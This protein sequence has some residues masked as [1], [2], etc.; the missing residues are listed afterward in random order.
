MVSAAVAALADMVS[1][2]IIRAAVDN[3]L[4]GKE[5]KL[6]FFL[7]APIKWAG[8]TAYLA[9]HI[10]IMAVAI[11]IVAAVKVIAQY[12]FRVY[13]TKGAETLTKTMRDRLFGHIERLPYAWHAK[14]RTG[15]IIQRCTSDI[16]TM[17]RFVSEQM[18]SIFRI[19]V[20]L[21]L[22]LGFM[23]SMN[24]KLTLVAM[25]PVPYIILR[26][27]QFH[28]KIGAAKQDV[29][30][31]REATV[32]ERRFW[33]AYIAGT[34][35]EMAILVPY[36]SAVDRGDLFVIAGDQYEVVQKDRKDTKPVSWLL[37][38]KKAVVRYAGNHS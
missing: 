24:W 23:L 34:E 19:L 14:H 37:S 6:P 4:G 30:H 26:S 18:T 33:D 35:L 22:S 27:F 32:G 29:I 31:F 17:K 10:W 2:Q 13:N 7:D 25:A 1:P 5:G 21:A 3:V 9:E 38:L 8:G 36:E 15:D 28:R 11:L 12:C 20:L 16:E